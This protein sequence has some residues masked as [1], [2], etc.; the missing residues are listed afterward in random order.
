MSEEVKK[1]GRIFFVPREKDPLSWHVGSYAAAYIHTYIIR[2]KKFRDLN[3]NW[4]YGWI[5]YFHLCLI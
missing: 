5:T 2:V 4:K 3:A 1:G